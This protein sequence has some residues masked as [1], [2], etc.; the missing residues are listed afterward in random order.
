MLQ[1]EHHM[2]AT[3]HVLNI[4]LP[5]DVA[6]LCS[7]EN[8]RRWGHVGGGRSLGRLWVLYWSLGAEWLCFNGED[9]WMESRSEGSFEITAMCSWEHM[10][11]HRPESKEPRSEAEAFETVSQHKPFSLSSILSQ[12][13]RNCHKSAVATS[14]YSDLRP[15][16]THQGLPGGANS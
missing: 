9:E 2:P 7:S 4:W 5:P 10:W 3:G 16:A 6:V 14:V 15:Q 13:W 1:F 11:Y 8:V 12:F